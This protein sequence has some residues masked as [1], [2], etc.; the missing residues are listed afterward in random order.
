MKIGLDSMNLGFVH[1]KKLMKIQFLSSHGGLEVEQW[2]DNSSL[3]ISVGSNPAR[4][5]KD[6]Y[7]SVFCNNFLMMLQG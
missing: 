6:L 1:L 7:K 5:Q 3:S 4:R 2:T